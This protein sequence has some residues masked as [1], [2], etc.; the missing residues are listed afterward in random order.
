MPYLLIQTNQCPDSMAQAALIRHLS[1]QLAGWLA[2]PEQY[3]VVA[4]QP[5]TAM[6]FGGSDA[7]CAYLELKSIGLAEAQLPEL[8]ARLCQAIGAGLGIAT[9]RIYIEFSAA[10]PQWWGWNGATF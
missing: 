10:Q 4:L 5:V 1:A 6:S 7:P 8:S 3:V 9:E 2:K